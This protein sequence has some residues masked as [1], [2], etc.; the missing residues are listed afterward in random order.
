MDHVTDPAK[1]LYRI[2]RD[3][4]FSKDKTPYKTHIAA[5]F[6]RNGLGKNTCAGFYFRVSHTGVEVAGGMYMPGP[7]ELLAVRQAIAADAD[8]LRKLIAS[9][10]LN[11]VMGEAHGHKLARV[12]K[13]FDANHPAGDLLRLKQLYFDVTLPAELALT[14]DIRRAVVD[15]FKL[16]E[17]VV[18]FMNDAALRKLTEEDDRDDK[19]PK[20]PEPMF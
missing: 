18:T 15:R 16:M 6:P 5:M 8:G 1:A 12:P 9:A 4:R 3:T 13:G 7:A 10:K 17:P 14:K 20:R 19:R 2:Y 11:R